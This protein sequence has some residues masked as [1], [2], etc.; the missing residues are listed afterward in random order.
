MQS[1]QMYCVTKCGEN[2]RSWVRFCMSSEWVVEEAKV[3]RPMNGGLGGNF[4]SELAK[5]DVFGVK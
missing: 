3:I 5:S 4:L 1:G 2:V